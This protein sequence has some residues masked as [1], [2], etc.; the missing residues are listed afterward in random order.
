MVTY[1]QTFGETFPHIEVHAPLEPNYFTE[2]DNS[3]L[4]GIEYI[5][6]YWTMNVE[7]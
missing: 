4:L 2:L 5:R 1:E 6:I 3:T 7:I